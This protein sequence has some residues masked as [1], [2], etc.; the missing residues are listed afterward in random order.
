MI[1]PLYQAELAHPDVRGLTTG[2]Q[3]FMLG[4]G[5]VCGSRI[6]YGTFVSYTDNRQWRIPFGIQI[7]P[8]TILSILIFLFLESPRWLIKKGR[9]E[10]G[11]KTLA[12]LHS[13][14]DLTDAWVLAEQQQI[15]DQVNYESEMEAK[16]ITEL[17]RTEANFRRVMLACAIQAATQMTSVFCDSVL[18]GHDFRKSLHQDCIY[19]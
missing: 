18:L 3:Q 10:E 16:S 17:F 13:K 1:I 14:G 5:G 8:A 7:I 12:R 6:S 11:L 2:L 19:Y 15:T 4:I 9:T